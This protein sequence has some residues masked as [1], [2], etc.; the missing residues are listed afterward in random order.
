VII[1][2]H[3][4]AAEVLRA[5]QDGPL[6]TAQIVDAIDLA[7]GIGKEEPWVK[8][9]AVWWAAVELRDRGM[10]KRNEIAGGCTWE[11]CRTTPAPVDP[12]ALEFRRAWELRR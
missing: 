1:I 10:V 4:L 8:Q 3:G 7:R 2:P 6:T 5:L 9:A 12:V 11:L